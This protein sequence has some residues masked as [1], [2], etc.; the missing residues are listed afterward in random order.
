MTPG[1]IVPNLI[2][3]INVDERRGAR[4]YSF[5]SPWVDPAGEHVYRSKHGTYC[6]VI[7]KHC[8]HGFGPVP[9]EAERSS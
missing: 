9:Q 3:F 2:S 6:E 7:P 8:R 4:R 1:W 5:Y